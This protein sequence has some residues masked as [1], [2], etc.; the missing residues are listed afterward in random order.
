MT[1]RY[2]YKFRPGFKSQDL[3]IDFFSGVENSEFGTDLMYALQEIKPELVKTEDVLNDEVLYFYSSNLGEFLLIKDIWNNAYIMAENNQNGIIAIELLLNVDSK[4][5]KIEV[6][7]NL[8][9]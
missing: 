2:K 9:K 5:E 8:F 7:N 1:G 3:L 4:F 6:D